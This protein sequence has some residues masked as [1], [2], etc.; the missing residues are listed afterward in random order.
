M[1][2]AGGGVPAVRQG[3]AS[4]SVLDSGDN[5]AVTIVE[6]SEAAN[7]CGRSVR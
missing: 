2:P 6:T 4:T 1:A 5:L 7:E 3:Q